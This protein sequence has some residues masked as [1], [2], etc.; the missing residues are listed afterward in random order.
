MSN[1]SN[2]EQLISEIPGDEGFYK[3]GTKAAYLS[4]GE[5][6]LQKGFTEEEAIEFLEN[7]WSATSDEYGN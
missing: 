3:S 4:A 7:L 5:E 6:L 2:F 1:K